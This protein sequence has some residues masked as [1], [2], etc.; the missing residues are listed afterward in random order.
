M[1]DVLVSR[2]KTYLQNKDQRYLSKCRFL[3]KSLRVTIQTSFPKQLEHPVASERCAQPFSRTQR[4]ECACLLAESLPV[5]S[6]RLWWLTRRKKPGSECAGDLKTKTIMT[7]KTSSWGAA[8]NGV[9]RAPHSAQPPA[10]CK[11]PAQLTQLPVTASRAA[12]LIFE[13]GIFPKDKITKS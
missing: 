2:K 10:T 1:Y 6:S 9:R 5:E 7:G 13:N 12:N 4:T 3:E 11:P 8:G